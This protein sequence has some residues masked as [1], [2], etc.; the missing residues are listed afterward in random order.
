MK[1]IIKYFTIIIL[2]TIPSFLLIDG[3]IVKKIIINQNDHAK[4]K[5]DTG[6]KNNRQ[7]F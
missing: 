1:K 3:W 6:Y 2:I 4:P 5:R 7:H